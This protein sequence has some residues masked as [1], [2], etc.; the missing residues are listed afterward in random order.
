MYEVVEALLKD[1]VR[2]PISS[3][4]VIGTTVS[5]APPSTA[6]VPASHTTG[7][8]RSAAPRIVRPFRRD[9][10]QPDGGN[11]GTRQSRV[12]PQKRGTT[13]AAWPLPIRVT[14][15]SPPASPV[16][17]GLTS[18]LSGLKLFN[19][20]IV[21]LTS[22]GTVCASGSSPRPTSQTRYGR[23]GAP[24]QFPAMTPIGFEWHE[25]VGERRC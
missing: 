7:F 13:R 3:H 9:R 1:C 14:A 2:R 22:S 25:A 17:D 4:E 23:S 8:S 21:R 12:A 6:A 18:A 15:Y 19:P 24:S 10:A 20:T 5:R 11:L 16:G